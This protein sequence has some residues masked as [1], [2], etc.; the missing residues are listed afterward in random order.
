L[1]ND[2][3][4]VKKYEEDKKF[5]NILFFND[6]REL[7]TY[8]KSAYQKYNKSVSLKNQK[9]DISKLFYKLKTFGKYDLYI[10]SEE[11]KR[12]FQDIYGDNGYKCAWC[13]TK[14]GQSYWNQY[15]HSG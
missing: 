2:Y 11:N 12:D 1:L 8:V 4:I 3:D 10:I 13:V 7:E 14:R 15:I 6:Y 9:K 5:K